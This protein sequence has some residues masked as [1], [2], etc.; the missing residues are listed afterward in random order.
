MVHVK[1]CK[2]LF[3]V[4]LFK[5]YNHIQSSNNILHV[6]REALTLSQDF[7]NENVLLGTHSL[8]VYAK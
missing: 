4:N 7:H 1:F 5:Y 6:L 3:G 2:F 8:Q